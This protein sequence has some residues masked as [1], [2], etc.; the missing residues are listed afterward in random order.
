MPTT[1]VLSEINGPGITQPGVGKTATKLLDAE[2]R[3]A[4]GLPEVSTT[5]K[6]ETLDG[7]ANGLGKDD[8]LKLLLAQ[9]SNQDPLKPMDD[10]QFI[11][12]LAQFNS[13]E[14][15]QQVNKNLLDMMSSQ[16]ISQASSL[17]GTVISG[18]DA[19]G[20]A[21]EG[22]VDAI[23][24]VDGQARLMVGSKRVKL[25]DV[26]DVYPLLD[27]L[28]P[29]GVEDTTDETD[30]TS[31]STASTGTTSGGTTT[32]P[33]VSSSGDMSGGTITP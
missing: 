12:Q 26:T 17:I 4:L 33:A 13:L 15:M 5:K 27:T 1:S 11:S 20:Q 2:T 31:S 21:V 25:G 7:T 32:N 19:T 10:T 9:L 28:P 6:K 30:G 24:M 3:A 22:I 8:F 16:Q 18:V 29:A 14:Q 23:T